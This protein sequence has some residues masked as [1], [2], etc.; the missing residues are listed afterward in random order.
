MS[1]AGFGGDAFDAGFLVV[2]YLGDCGVGFVAAWWADAFPFVVDSG[3][4]FEEFFEA[5]SAVEGAGAPET[6]DLSDGW[7][8]GD[9]ALLA[10]FLFDEFE[11]E[12]GFEIIWAD[13][14]FGVWV[15]W[16]VWWCFEVCLD[17]VPFFWEIVFV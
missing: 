11:G 7:W 1:S 16:W 4:C 10:D 15:E 6:V 3:W 8:Y 17:V 9:V 14:L 2:V 5:S 12:D 13:G